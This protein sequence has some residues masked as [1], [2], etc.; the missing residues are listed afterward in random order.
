MKTTVSYDVSPLNLT[1]LGNINVRSML[2][3]PDANG[4]AFVWFETS[5]VVDPARY[6]AMSY[7][8]TPASA[9]AFARILLEKADL[10][11]ILAHAEAAKRGAPK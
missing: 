8:L 6:Q 10:A 11:E 3:P 5:N 2:I 4:E 1:R 7:T 9:K